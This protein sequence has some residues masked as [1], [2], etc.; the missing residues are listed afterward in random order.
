MNTVA[1]ITV[2][3]GS[4]IAAAGII[5][6]PRLR[7]LVRAPAR[8]NE[9]ERARLLALL[10]WRGL[11]DARQLERLPRLAARLVTDVR[12]IGCQ[13]LDVTHDMRLA[14]AG[15][16]SLLCLGA[17]PGTFALPGEVLI[18]PDAFYIHQTEPDENGLVDDLPLLASGEAW[19]DS[20]VVLSWT[21]VEAALAGAPHN[22]VLHEFAHLLDFAA[23][24]QEGAPPMADADRW[25]HVFGEAF[26]QLREQ[27]SPVID[28]YGAQNLAEFFAV[29]V[30]AFF[31]RGAEL[32]SHHSELYRT[33]AAYF[34][35]DT[36]RQPPAFE[37]LF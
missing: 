19:D 8:L 11:L 17:T 29:A 36:A 25:T 21:D 32:A 33:M 14:I 35:I 34:D 31:Q 5:A 27:G 7:L 12:F 30:E 23:P 9:G 16:A 4:L 10:P 24:A 20:R 3:V 2:L 22:V 13:G 26:E 6:Y 18:Y 37:D 15:Q 28:I 1:A